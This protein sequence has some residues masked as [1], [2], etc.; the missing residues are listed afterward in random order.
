MRLKNH[1]N[2]IGR[3]GAACHMSLQFL[4][5]LLLVAII[6]LRICSLPQFGNTSF[7]YL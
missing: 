2:F 4:T 7:V 1:C 6:L 3:G 5:S